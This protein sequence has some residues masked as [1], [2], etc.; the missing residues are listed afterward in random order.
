MTNLKTGQTPAIQVMERMFSLLDAL[1]AH[2]DP[3]SLK[4]LSDCARAS[5]RRPPSDSAFDLLSMVSMLR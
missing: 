2:Q 5:R 4:V 3:V 1:A